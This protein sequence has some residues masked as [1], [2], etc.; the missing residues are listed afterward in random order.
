MTVQN[1]LEELLR[2]IAFGREHDLTSLDLSGLDVLGLPRDAF[3]GLSGLT[4]L[5]L[6]G[7]GHLREIESLSGLSRLQQLD[8]SG[9][10]RLDTVQPLAGLT[11][12][13]KLAL[14]GCKQLVD[15]APLRDLSSLQRLELGGC[16]Q[17]REL[18]PPANLASLLQLDLRGCWQLHD[19]APLAGFSSLQRLDLSW[20]RQIVELPPLAGLPLH[21]LDLSWCG[22]IQS[23]QPLAG[24]SSLQRLGL[25]GCGRRFNLQALAGLTSLQS[26]HLIGGPALDCAP[27]SQPWASWKNVDEVFADRLLGAPNELRS[28]SG[29][30]NVLPRI[31]AWESD[32]L[33]GEAPASRVK[34]FILGNGSVGKTQVSRRLRGERFDPSEPSTHGIHRGVIEIARSQAG[35][36]SVVAHLWDFGGQDIYLGTHAL[37]LDAQAIY[38]V[39][40]NPAHE[41]TDAFEE[42]GVLMRNR[43][44]DYWLAYVRDYAGPDACVIVVQT[45]CEREEDVRSAPI[46]DE[47]D[48]AR[49][50]E[51]SACA[52]QESGIETLQSELELAA[53]YQLERYGRVLIPANWVAMAETLQARSAEKT[54]PRVEFDDLCRARHRAA[55]PSVVLD[56]LHRSGQVFWREGFFGNQV[57]L[58]QDWALQGVY[59]VLDRSVVMPEIR[60]RRGRFSLELLA[61]LAWQHYGEPEQR[62]FMSLME[63]C[64]ICFKVAD[65][66]FIA[67]ALLPSRNAVEEEIRSVWRDAT[68]QARVRLDYPFLHEGVLRAL[69]CGMGVKAG[70]HAVYWA[71]GV[72]FYD[73]TSRSQA[74]V[75][76]S[77]PNVAAARSGGSIVI[78]TNGPGALPLARHLSSSI[79]RLVSGNG[80]KVIWLLGDAGPGFSSKGSSD[81]A[82][83]AIRVEPL[84]QAAS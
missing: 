69:V 51:I 39:A 29:G 64:Q 40:W 49:L 13:Q 2:R 16:E 27:G 73:E 53:Q 12:L 54:L 65:D 37:F 56:Y 18:P 20:C 55:L 81:E 60:R 35:L 31:R 57:V 11:S 67:P 78:E 42:N 83:S 9:C 80:P 74:L 46:T 41:N 44:L 75:S 68:P 15:V 52:S 79:E 4:R 14:G 62:L 8:L 43:P 32:L 21:Q 82:F 70:V 59:A 34:L 38:V 50:R 28:T 25:T 61:E 5:D 48:F 63:Q 58:D 77:A 71:F 45:Q 30:D 76:S 26:V 3:A 7:C 6:S 66:V 72:C 19:L 33:A 17:L 47:Y 23:L 1:H 84:P 36:P 22:Q 10:K 24:L